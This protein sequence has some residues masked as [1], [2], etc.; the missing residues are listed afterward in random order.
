MSQTITAKDKAPAA[1]SDSAP[2]DNANLRAA[3]IKYQD[4]EQ[5]LKKG[6]NI[7]AQ[8]ALDASIRDVEREWSRPKSSVPQETV[9]RGGPTFDYLRNYVVGTGAGGRLS[10]D[11]LFDSNPAQIDELFHHM[12][13]LQDRWILGGTAK[14]RDIVL[15]AH[16]GLVPEREGLKHV[17][18]LETW[19]LNNKIYAVN[20]VWQSGVT[21][22]MRSIHQHRKNEHENNDR[23]SDVQPVGERALVL[24]AVLVERAARKLLSPLWDEMKSN[25]VRASA[26]LATDPNWEK[27][28]TIPNNLPG[29]SLAISRL[30]LYYERHPDI[31][32]HLV[33]HSAGSIYC[34]GLIERLQQYKIPIASVT[35]LAPA[36]R[37][38]DFKAY[39]VPR[40]TDGAISKLTIFTL[41]GDLE[42]NDISAVKG[43]GYR[44]SILNLVSKSL[45]SPGLGEDEN[46]VPILGLCKYYSKPISIFSRTTLLNELKAH[47]ATLIMS[48]GDKVPSDSNAITHGDFDIDS[49]T[50]N[51]VG[52]L[53][54]HSDSLEQLFELPKRTR[55]SAH[56]ELE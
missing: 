37:V 49:S 47:N 54:L 3:A 8:E 56:E 46:D 40:L 36:L 2:I 10:S 4:Y 33:G 31:K 30:K 20:F 28:D 14:E 18:D 21:E 26:P 50:L 42:D 17:V 55:H 43:V 53:I 16:G 41:T 6:A 7:D 48:S 44:G 29:A 34:L 38:D 35:F 5:L 23:G 51:T 15:Y 52:K 45:E 25:A 24:P 11:D 22:T 13:S 9:S 1:A 27:I 19:W 39:V 32:I 12:E